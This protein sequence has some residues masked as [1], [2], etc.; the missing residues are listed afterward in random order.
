MHASGDLDLSG[1]PAGIAHRMPMAEPATHSTF[2]FASLPPSDAYKLLASTV[3]PRPIAWITT[4][5]TEGRINAAPYS[6]FNVLSSNPP[7]MAIGFSG[8]P[9]RDGKDSLA[10]IRATGQLVVNLVSEELAQAMNITATDAPRGV[11]ELELADLAT[12]PSTQ[13]TPPRIAA[14]P[15][16]FECETF[17]IIELEGPGTILLA[18]VLAAHI[19]KDIFTDESRL[20]VDA[21]RM[22]LVG[23]LHSP[24]GYCTTRDTFEIDRIPWSELREKR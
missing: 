21:Q 8:A 9:D 16:S 22:H 4:E 12:A 7:L 18:K 10:N 6:F 5:D 3:L 19:R 1:T 20:H 15:V 2:D 13:V 11:D 24:N 14:S 23:R 17:Q